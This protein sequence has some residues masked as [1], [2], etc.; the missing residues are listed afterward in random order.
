MLTLKFK[1]NIRRENCVATVAPFLDAESNIRD[2]KVD[3]HHPDK[4][5]TILG[6]DVDPQ[7]VKNAVAQAGYQVEVL[8]VYGSAGGVT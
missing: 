1:T 7:R 4:I 3:T 2:W 6:T 8:Q 5:L